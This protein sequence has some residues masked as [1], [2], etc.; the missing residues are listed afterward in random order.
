MSWFMEFAVRLSLAMVLLARRL[1]SNILRMVSPMKRLLYIDSCV[2]RETSRTKRIADALVEHLLSTGKY[3]LEQLVLEDLGLLPLTSKTLAHRNEMRY[4][5]EYDDAMF[6]LAHQFAEA[7]E[8]V[9]AAPFWEGAYPALLK[10]YFER[11]SVVGIVNRYTDH[12][13]VGMCRASKLHYITTRGGFATDEQDLG[14]QNVKGLAKVYGIGSVDCI[15]VNATD[16][17]TTDVDAAVAAAIAGIPALI[18]E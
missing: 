7:D 1:D 9:I 2:L 17:P 12:G 14:W 18:G 13:P 11:I 8:I 6:D 3:V 10:V 16:V 5:E 15:S 4:A